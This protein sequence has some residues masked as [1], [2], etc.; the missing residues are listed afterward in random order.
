MEPVRDSRLSLGQ[1][2]GEGQ[3][4]RGEIRALRRARNRHSVGGPASGKRGTRNESD[5]KRS[6]FKKA[7]VRMERKDGEEV[8]LMRNNKRRMSREKSATQSPR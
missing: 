2:P 5:D 1:L 7:M 3:R 4:Q 8:K 6:K